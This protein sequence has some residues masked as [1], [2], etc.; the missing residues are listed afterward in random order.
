MG[1]CRDEQMQEDCGMQQCRY[2]GYADGRDGYA[3]G[4]RLRWDMELSYVKIR[5]LRSK[6]FCT[7]SNKTMMP[8]SGHSLSLRDQLRNRKFV[9]YLTKMS[10]PSWDYIVKVCLSWD[11]FF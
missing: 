7:Y 5:R 9:T 11:G 6:Y 4:R 10:G 2:G 8:T 1:S 3:S